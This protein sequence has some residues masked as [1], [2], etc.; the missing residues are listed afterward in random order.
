MTHLVALQVEND[1]I[2]SPCGN[3]DQIMI[4]YSKAG[5]GTHFDPATKKVT[6]VPLGTKLTADMHAAAECRL[7]TADMHAAADC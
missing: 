5:M 1:F 3:L 2:G 7:L 4:Y 6:Y